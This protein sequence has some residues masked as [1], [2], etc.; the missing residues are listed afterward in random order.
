MSSSELS[1]ECLRILRYRLAH[2]AIGPSTARKMGP[3]GTIGRVRS[4]LQQIALEDF[5]VE[6]AGAFYKH[7]D[8]QTA[9]LQECAGVAWGAARKFLNIFLRDALYNRWMC[10]EFGLGKIEDLLELP[11]DSHTAKGLCQ[12]AEDHPEIAQ[13]LPRWPGVVNLT[14]ALSDQYQRLASDVAAL[15]QVARVHLDI[16][17]WRQMEHSNPGTEIQIVIDR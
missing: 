14:P 11:L 4:F 15:K 17:Y 3:P 10:A 6:E 8:S 1:Q 16:L 7:L 9:G 12:A 2:T 13:Q 5:V